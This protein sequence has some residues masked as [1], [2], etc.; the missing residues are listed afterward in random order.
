MAWRNETV[1]IGD[2]PFDGDAAGHPPLGEATDW[3]SY[4]DAARRMGKL[5]Y[6]HLW[7][8][9]YRYA[10]SAMTVG[11]SS[12]ATPRYGAWAKGTPGLPIMDAA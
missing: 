4:E 5:D 11:G 6:D 8:C 1:R 2:N 7:A 3:H 10:I 9:D 12:R